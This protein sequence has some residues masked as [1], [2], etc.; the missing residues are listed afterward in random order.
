MKLL[1]SEID[2]VPGRKPLKQPL[3][4]G[5]VGTGV[6]TLRITN[7]TP[8]QNSYT[9]RLVCDQEFW[10]DAWYTVSA[11]APS[12]GPENAPPT[13]KP[14]QAG[15]R[16]QSLTIFIRDGGMRDVLLSLFVPEKSE[17]RAGVYKARVVVETRVLSD[18]P[19]AAR[20][21]RITEIPVSIIVRPFHKWEIAFTPEERRVGLFKRKTD[22]ELIV[23]NQGND[24]LYCDLT[25]PRPQNV[26]IE[27]MVQRLAVPPPEPGTDSVRTVPVTAVTRMRTVRGPRTPTALPLTVQRVD[28]PS[29][30]P[31]PEEAAYSPSSAN[32]GSAV[33]AI[34]T[35][36][37]GIPV[38]PAKVL[39]CPPVPDTFTA[40]MEAI[41][42]NARGLVFAVIGAIL[43]WQ[44]AVFTYE[45]YWKS[46]S[47]VRVA[48]S[49]VKV[50]EAFR[51]RGK[52]LVGSHILL[53]DP[54]TKAQIGEPLV[55]KVEPKSV[56]QD[57]VVVAI[58]DRD[59]EGRKVV[60]GAQRLGKLTFLNGFLPVIKD[61]TPIMIGQPIVKTGPPSGSVTANVAPGQSLTIGGVNFGATAGKVLID[62]NGAKILSWN[63][64][65][66]KAEVPSDKLLGD[67][68]S[69]AAFTAAGT[70]IPIS[71]PTVTIK[72]PGST[73]VPP[74]AEPSIGPDGEL[75]PPGTTGSTGSTSGQGR[76]ENEVPTPP[77]DPGP[78]D[79][80]AE[81][82]SLPPAYDRLLSD[83]RADYTKAVEETR[84][85]K[86]TGGLA[87]QAYALAALNRDDE[88]KTAVR[89]ALTQIG[90]RSEGKD[91]AL[92]LLALAKI[93]ENVNPANAVAAYAKADAQV[94]KA[95]P[96]FAFKD[97][98][99]ARSK[100]SANSNFE[101]KIVLQDAL[102]KQPTA[103]ERSAIQRMLTKVAK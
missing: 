22:F 33:V 94:D 14:D 62:G 1:H 29:V 9:I 72:V 73:D 89:K 46:I 51:I 12:G 31:L 11:V 103:A 87:V 26:M 5:F 90:D 47:D 92:C 85:L 30:P 78:Q 80:I 32:L 93:V 99:I 82:G 79:P 50:G 63:D 58:N 35:G 61:P 10:Q 44:L 39:Y 25:L 69:V 86:S 19:H 4:E 98:V 59:L 37:V 20:K 76:N 53:Y 8:R 7:T 54:S 97:L 6:G 24:W 16:N 96:G 60:I 65:T 49:T 102:K 83:K 34:E 40:F 81:E 74:D 13:G 68:F 100:V 18:E 56:V 57:Y 21:E 38:A 52:N 101:A 84:R 71:P 42:R 41:V 55:P 15:P 27:T 3:V 66:I 91:Y 28:A 17:C 95:A 2:V 36:E 67:T 45:V 64:G 48:R 70:S 75:V 23:T 43:A 77:V 88:A